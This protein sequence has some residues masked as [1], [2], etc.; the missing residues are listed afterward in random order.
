MSLYGEEN[1]SAAVQTCSTCI[2]WEQVRA[3]ADWGKCGKIVQITKA[4]VGESRAYV[5]A[6]QNDGAELAHVTLQTRNTFV[7]VHY[8]QRPTADTSL[9]NA[10]R[11]AAREHTMRIR[12]IK[13]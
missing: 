10:V 2:H 7:C 1:V 9:V 6:T 4:L 12:E 8:E 5:F 11:N 13:S 3:N